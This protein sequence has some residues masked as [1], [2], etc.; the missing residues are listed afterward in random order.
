MPSRSGGASGGRSVAEP[1][2]LPGLKPP[3]FVPMVDP[4]SRPTALALV[5]PREGTR[6]LSASAAS[7]AS[8]AASPSRYREATIERPAPA[9]K[10]AKLAATQPIA[11]PSKYHKPASASASSHPPT[12]THAISADA[13]GFFAPTAHM[14]KP[15]RG[16]PEPQPKPAK[17]AMGAGP[18]Y[19][20]TAAQPGSLSGPRSAD[21]AV[22]G[23]AP[24]PTR[25]RP[26]VIPK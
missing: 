16:T 11:L 5:P 22:V 19:G 20:L 12:L 23:S 1:K 6:Q 14:P 10:P 24:A 13:I 15:N 26:I 9:T 18:K 8:T 7:L 3:T 17:R 2:P 25:P 21:E 4:L